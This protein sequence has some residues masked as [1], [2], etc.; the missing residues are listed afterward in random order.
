[1]KVVITGAAGFIGRKLAH[2]LLDRGSVAGPDGA[3]LSIEHLALIDVVPSAPIADK[4][5][6]SIVGDVGD[7]AFLEKVIGHDTASIFHLAGVVSAGAEANFELGYRVNLDGT[8]AL[9]EL[10]RAAP[11]TPRIVFTSSIAVYGGDIPA[12]IDDDVAPNP[13]TSYGTQKLIC[14]RLLADYTRKGYVDGRGLRLP[15]IMVRTGKP[16][17][18]ASTWASSIIRE[19]LAGVD[20]VSPVEA[21]SPMACLSARRTIDAL[22]RMHDLPSEALGIDRTVLLSGISVTAGEM[23]EAVS[24]NAGNRKVGEISWQPDPQTQAIV[25]GWPKGTESPRAKALG[26]TTDNDIDEIVRAFIDDDL[27]AQIRDFT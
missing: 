12:I 10:C 9:L 14:E 3:P 17:L 13:Q 6:T 2:E 22:V 7:P 19:P 21:R 18:A 23:A 15:T 27:D 4:R 5:V 25:D 24:R 26:F 1:M 16:N 20:F 11:D 8:R